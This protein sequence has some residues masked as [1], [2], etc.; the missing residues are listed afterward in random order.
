M[1]VDGADGIGFGTA[2]E[3]LQVRFD[4]GLRYTVADLLCCGKNLQFCPFSTLP[5]NIANI[6][7]PEGETQL[8]VGYGGVPLVPLSP[9]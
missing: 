1:P 8:R 9:V 4:N 3:Y 5:T 7:H 2:M 6:C